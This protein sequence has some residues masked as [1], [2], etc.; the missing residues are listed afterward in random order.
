L[1]LFYYFTLTGARENTQKVHITKLRIIYRNKTYNQNINQLTTS[2]NIQAVID[3][4][5]LNRC[6]FVHTNG[7]ETRDFM[8]TVPAE[9]QPQ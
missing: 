5:N 1:F 6:T 7:V 8:S 9:S 2:L 3:E 4:N